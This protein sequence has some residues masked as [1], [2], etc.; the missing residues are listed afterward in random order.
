M[1]TR[2]RYHLPSDRPKALGKY[3]AHGITSHSAKKRHKAYPPFAEC[4]PAVRRPS[5]GLTAIRLCCVQ[6]LR[7]L[8]KAK[9]CRVPNFQHSVNLFYFLPSKIFLFRVP[10]FQHS[11][12]LFFYLLPSKIFLFSSNL[13]SYFLMIYDTFINCFT[14]YHYV[15]RILSVEV[16]Y[17][18]QVDQNFKIIERKSDIHVIKS[19]SRPYLR[20]D[21]K[22]ETS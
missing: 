1:D 11:A 10:N 5:S 18:L 8:A 12:N 21:F 22:F 13:K 6:P 17:E 3:S 7:H 4:L 9:L 14:I 16:K 20:K 19:K 2:Q 15:C